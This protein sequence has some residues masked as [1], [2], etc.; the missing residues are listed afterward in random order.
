MGIARA[1]AGFLLAVA[2]RSKVPP[3]YTVAVN[4]LWLAAAIG[5]EAVAL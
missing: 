2:A 3:D 1:V 5:I 4:M